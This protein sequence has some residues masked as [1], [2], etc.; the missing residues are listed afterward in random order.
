MKLK[1]KTKD[2]LMTMGAVA[3]MC[4]GGFSLPG[5]AHNSPLAGQCTTDSDCEWREQRRNLNWTAVRPL[6]EI[7]HISHTTQHFGSNR[8]NYGWNVASFGVRW[9]PTE[10]VVVDLLEGYSLEEM[11]GRHE[12]FTGR[13]TVEF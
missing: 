4:L 5:C 12:V 2:R 9:R 11:N 10:G 1:P 6:T 8:T 7:Q 13:I 3:L